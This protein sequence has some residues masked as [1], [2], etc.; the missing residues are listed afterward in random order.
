M[1][2]LGINNSIE[3]I[4]AA[5]GRFYDPELSYVELSIEELIQPIPKPSSGAIIL[6]GAQGSQGGP[7]KARLTFKS[8]TEFLVEA[9]TDGDGEYDYDSDLQ[10][11]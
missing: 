4:S 5:I 6:T 2:Y 8:A 7:T 3:A 9:D 1:E 11:W 10:L